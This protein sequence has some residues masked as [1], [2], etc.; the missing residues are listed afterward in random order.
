MSSYNNTASRKLTIVLALTALVLLG[1]S[2]GYAQDPNLD[3]PNSLTLDDLTSGRVPTVT[4]GDKTFSLFSYTPAGD[5]PAAEDINVLDFV[6]LEGHF[7]ISLQGAFLDNPGDANASTALLQFT[8]TVSDEGQQQGNRIS[9]A[10]LFLGGSGVPEESEFSVVE[11][12]SN[13]AQTLNVFDSTVGGGTQQQ[14][15]DWLDFEQTTLS[16]DI[17]LEIS[18]FA[19]PQATLPARATAIDLT[20]SQVEIPE[21]STAVLLLLTG[22][23]TSARRRRS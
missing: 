5:M 22:L 23:S 11:S 1:T 2:T 21:P 9:D 14:L 3:D 17:A 20:I 6:D 18:A 10:H 19:D 7:G 13:T 12:F 4:V 15:S 16:L 8:V